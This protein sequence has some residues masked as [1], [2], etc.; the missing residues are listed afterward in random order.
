MR[1]EVG[2]LLS[3]KRCYSQVAHKGFELPATIIVL[4]IWSIAVWLFNLQVGM[5]FS[6]GAAVSASLTSMALDRSGYQQAWMQLGCTRSCSFNLGD[7]YATGLSS[8]GVAYIAQAPAD[9]L[10][11]YGASGS[12]SGTLMGATDANG[13]GQGSVS[14]MASASAGNSR[15]SWAFIDPMFTIDASYLAAHPEASLT[16]PPGVGNAITAVP[17]PQALLLMLAGLAALALRRRA[18]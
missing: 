15:L 3:K 1:S 10:G 7:P 5:A 11:S 6:N 13:Q 8:I 12:F 4:I 18:A 2:D 16:L 17:E 9:I 14:L